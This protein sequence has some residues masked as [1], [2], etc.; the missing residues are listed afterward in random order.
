[1]MEQAAVATTND[2]TGGV[3]WKFVAL[4]Y[5]IAFGMVSLLS[6]G[7][8]LAGASFTAGNASKAFLLAV[9]LAACCMPMP[10]AAG[11]IVERVARRR[12]LMH[13]T[14]S[15]LASGWKRVLVISTAISLAVYVVNLALV[16]LLGNLLDL[17]GVGSLISRQAQLVANLAAMLPGQAVAQGTGSS[18][19]PVWALYI[20]GLFLGV[21]A[22]AT[23]NGLFGFGEEYGWRG[24][25]M[26]ELRPLGVVR[27]NILTGILWGL[28]H[29]PLILLGFHFGQQ[30]FL[31]VLVMCLWVTPFSFLLWRAREYS[32]SVIAPAI[33]HGAFNGSAG[34]FLVLVSDRDALISAPVGLVGALSMS[35]LA[36]AIW[37][38]ELRDTQGR[39]L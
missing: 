21:L 4:F 20:I 34:F 36:A 23:I 31:G 14:L 17:R 2:P 1:M 22:G 38:L 24:V 16:A 28:W 11:L 13:D 35:I 6:A 29:V 39:V 10:C 33:I 27:A 12:P 5:A 32:G 37:C 9:V 25:L 7:F 18:M 30:R 3:A 26:D 15:A 8:A 19:P